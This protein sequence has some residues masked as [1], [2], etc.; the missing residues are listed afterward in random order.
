MLS[1]ATAKPGMEATARPA[2]RA[3]RRGDLYQADCPTRGILDHMTSRWGALVLVLLL[4]RTHRFSELARRIGG[5]SEKMLS[6]T[7]QVLEADGFVLR[8]VCATV[9]PNV[10]YSLTELGRDGAAH[11][12]ALTDWVNAMLRPYCVSARSMAR[13]H[14]ELY[15][16]YESKL[17]QGADKGWF[18]SATIHRMT[19]PVVRKT[20]R[21]LSG[22]ACLRCRRDMPLRVFSAFL[23]FVLGFPLPA[24][25]QTHAEWSVQ[26]KPLADVVADV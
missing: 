8:T 17:S 14:L 19:K 20:I 3:E 12:A 5:V 23:A 6:Q 7:L 13:K 26:E 9:P 11:V 16:N 1:Q 18:A 2:A 21:H 25:C 4:E 22:L 10:E 24:L 15:P